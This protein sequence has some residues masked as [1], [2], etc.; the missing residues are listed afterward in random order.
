MTA[1]QLFAQ[2]DE[3]A[4][5]GISP[6]LL[7]HGRWA[8][9]GEIQRA[10]LNPAVDWESLRIDRSTYDKHIFES[11]DKVRCAVCLD[12]PLRLIELRTIG[13]AGSTRWTGTR[14]YLLVHIASIQ[15]LLVS[16]QRPRDGEH[17]RG[18]DTVTSSSRLAM[19]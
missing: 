2:P 18:F 7:T 6:L 9:R 17:A 12:H 8:G 14:P 10:L 3:R 1:R 4:A 15:R 11:A 5:K 13:V 16:L 19:M